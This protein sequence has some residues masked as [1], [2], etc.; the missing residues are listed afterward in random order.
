MANETTDHWPALM[1]DTTAAKYVDM[2][3]RL[4]W[5]LAS[6]NKFPKPVAI[7]GARASRWKRS[8]LD[9]YLSD[10]EAAR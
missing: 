6:A 5:K 1:R 9:A 4:I 7:P 8:D 3:A 2:S 10:L